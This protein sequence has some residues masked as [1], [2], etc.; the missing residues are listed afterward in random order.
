MLSSGFSEAGVKNMNGGFPEDEKPFV[1]NYDY[2]MDSDLD[3]DEEA[4][5]SKSQREPSP[6]KTA[7]RAGRVI[8]IRDASHITWVVECG[9][10]TLLSVYSF[11]AILVFLHTGEIEFRKLGDP[12]PGVSSKSVYRLADKVRLV[13]FFSCHQS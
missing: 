5:V 11:Y 2:E 8:V 9:K 3:E 12:K 4:S 7:E 10:V 1:D 13:D 6:S